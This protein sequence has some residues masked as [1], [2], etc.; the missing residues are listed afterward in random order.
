M[1]KNNLVNFFDRHLINSDYRDAFTKHGFTA[2][3]TYFG[4]VEKGQPRVYTA[5]F[6]KGC[7]MG[8]I[9]EDWSAVLVSI[10]DEW[11][12]L[13]EFEKD[14]ANKVGPMSVQKP[15]DERWDDI[16]HYYEDILLPSIPIDRAAINATVKEFSKLGGLHPR[17]QHLTV[18]KMKKST[19]SGSPDFTR[20]RNVTQET[21]PANVFTSRSGR[22]PH[23]MVELDCREFYTPAILGWRGQE[24]GPSPWDTKQRV[25][26]MFP[27]AVNVAEL[28]VYQPLIE[29]A[30]HFNIVPAWVSMDAVDKEVTALFDTK[31]VDD[32]VV[33]TDFSRFD[34]HFNADLQ[35]AARDILSGIL[36]TSSPAKVWLSQ[37]FPAKYF[38]QLAVGAKGNF[39]QTLAGRHGMASGSGGTNVDETL[40]HRALQYEVAMLNDQK[41][42]THSMCLGDDGILTYPGITVED[43]VEAYSSHGQECNVSKQYASTQD[44]VYLRRWHHTDYRVDGVC[45]GVYSTNR[46]LGRLRY[47]ER[48]MDPEYWSPEMVALRQLSIIENCKHHPL[49]E[50]FVQFCMARDKYRLGLDL[51]GFLDG[52]DSLA[53]EAIDHMPDFLGYTKTLQ[54]EGTGL[55][56]WWVVKYLKSLR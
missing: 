37:V 33:C 44:C 49:R 54:G 34:Q 51:P 8:E 41:L 42:N 21:I 14:L 9:L 11:P 56:S 24:G 50:Q 31:G 39:L 1:P 45:V 3:K 32:L 10:Q 15:L 43:V 20:R 38:I 18:E 53:K 13:W 46:A 47:L 4:N 35:A 17:S 52:V 30:Q 27:Y 29:K 25:I 16:A 2:F 12:T 48:F 6:A 5:P 7:T 23:V 22:R 26:W 36:N 40:T 28:Q 55:S 19:N